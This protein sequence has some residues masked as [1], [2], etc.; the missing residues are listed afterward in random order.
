MK[1]NDRS[2]FDSRLTRRQIL[3]GG[4]GVLG[5]G[6]LSTTW[7]SKARGNDVSGLYS[8][9]L[10]ARGGALPLAIQP[11]SSGPTTSGTLAIGSS[12]VG[13]VGSSFTGLSVE[14]SILAIPYFSRNNTDLIGLYTR[15]GISQ[16]RIGG[17]S[18]DTTQWDPNGKGRASGKVAPSDIDALAAFLRATGWKAL[19]G[20]NLA[21]S[22]PEAAASEVSYVVQSL[23]DY[24]FGIEIGN[25]CNSYKG[26]YFPTWNLQI[27][28]DRWETFRNAIVQAAP[29]VVLTGPGTSGGTRGITNW[30]VPFGRDVGRQQI[31]L[32]TQ[33]YYRGPAADSSSTAAN[34]ISPDATLVEDLALLKTGAADIGV[35]FRVTETNS[36]SGG[37]KQ[38][39]SNSY[40]SAL[41][42]IDHLFTIALGGCSGANLHGGGSG[43]Y[44]PIASTSGG[45][46]SGVRPEYYGMLLFTLAGQG[47]LLRTN[48]SVE[49]LDATAYAVQASDGSLSLVVVNKDATQNLNLRVDCGRAVTSASLIAMTAPA[50]EATNGVQIQGASVG[51][52]GSF[53]PYPPDSLAC[54]GSSFSCQVPALN[55][56]LIHV[57]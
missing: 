24:L 21:T 34:L 48:L 28:E 10:K 16:L 37:G 43:S 7:L 5:G 52:D 50:L 14:K 23:G 4:L 1:Q 33:H 13:S 55:A 11:V 47:A 35:P 41:W 15:L 22:T 42:V 27:F 8:E 30:A 56:A 26:K 46:V 36:Y 39:V 51:L 9:D 2:I 45:A 31:A 25:E 6:I 3:L 40:A 20:V 32:L 38:G 12:Q 53:N 49:G 44:T 54:S 19:Y 57:L 29:G 17:G 18:V